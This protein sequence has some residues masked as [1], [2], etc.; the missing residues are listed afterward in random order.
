MT[1]ADT[2]EAGRELDAEIAEQVMGWQ[3]AR[4]PM[5]AE[6]DLIILVEKK[7]QAWQELRG[8]ERLDASRRI[9]NVP[10]YSTDIAAAW[11]VVEKMRALGFDFQCRHFG[12]YTVTFTPSRNLLAC[13]ESADGD[14]APLA[15]FLAA[16][17]MLDS[18]QEP[19]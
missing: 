13:G 15:I 11:L 19:T 17:A 10:R 1:T 5:L 2:H 12:T 6:D 4:S 14:T 8:H 16:K 9:G 18:T 3:R 7:D